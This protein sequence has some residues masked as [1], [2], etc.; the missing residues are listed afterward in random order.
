MDKRCV[1]KRCG[2]HW[3]RNTDNPIR[4]PD[5][6]TYHWDE[7]P[8]VNKCQSCGHEWFSRTDRTPIRCP[9]CKTRTWT[10]LSKRTRSE[11]TSDNAENQQVM[12]LYNAGKGCISISLETGLSFAMVYDIVKR[13]LDSQKIPRM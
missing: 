9:S 13:N 7:E 11:S 1:C 4:C 8:T 5:C 6:G 3:I 2:Y 12:S 10:T